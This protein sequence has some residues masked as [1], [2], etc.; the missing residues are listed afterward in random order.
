MIVGVLYKNEVD[1][2]IIQLFMQL[3]VPHYLLLSCDYY[4]LI[5]INPFESV[6][7]TGG[8]HSILTRNLIQKHFLFFYS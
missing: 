8:P 3:G 5:V 4:L 6:G 2:K 7:S 1:A